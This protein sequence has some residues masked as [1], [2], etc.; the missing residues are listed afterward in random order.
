M[1]S[2]E[3]LPFGD[4]Q[5]QPRVLV[6]HCYPPGR[7][8]RAGLPGGVVRMGRSS[9]RDTRLP[10]VHRPAAP[11]PAP[12]FPRAVRVHAASTAVHTVSDVSPTF[13]ALLEMPFYGLSTAP[14]PACGELF[15]NRASNRFS[16]EYVT[17][18][19]GRPGTERRFQVGPGG[20]ATRL[21]WCR[22]SVSCQRGPVGQL[23]PDSQGLG[24]LVAADPLAYQQQCGELIPRGCGV[25]GAP[26]PVS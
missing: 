18:R 13:H 21:A 16:E 5:Q 8:L 25:P 26:G 15:R 3:R 24:M 7:R 4:H 1:R 23:V 14:C 6:R 11:R 20:P 10:P 12:S 17:L 22:A 19:E 2:R 9:P